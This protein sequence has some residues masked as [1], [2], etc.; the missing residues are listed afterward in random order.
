MKY[1]EEL[2]PV[3]REA[4]FSYMR[5]LDKEAQRYESE[6]RRLSPRHGEL[7]VGSAAFDPFLKSAVTDEYLSA[8]RKGETP[9]EA[10]ATA[11]DYGRLCVKKH[12]EKRKDINWARWIDSGTAHAENLHRNTPTAPTVDPAYP[13]SE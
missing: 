6:H 3:S 11:I 13:A 10:E 5:K 2:D 9:D 12:N 8:L 1:F 4:L 7:S